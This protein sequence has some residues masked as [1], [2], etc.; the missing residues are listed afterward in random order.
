MTRPR[1]P[2]RCL[3]PLLIV[4]AIVIAYVAWRDGPVP[5]WVVRAADARP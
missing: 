4:A 5:G 3:I 2:S 1:D